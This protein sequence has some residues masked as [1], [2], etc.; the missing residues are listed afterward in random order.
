MLPCQDCL[1]IPMCR[2]KEYWHMLE[3]CEL[4]YRCLYKI[5]PLN[6]DNRTIIFNERIRDFEHILKPTTW[7]LE[8][9]HGYIRIT[10]VDQ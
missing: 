9:M 5:R 8:D 2:H 4:I 3:T 1:M 10:G 7:A 6:P